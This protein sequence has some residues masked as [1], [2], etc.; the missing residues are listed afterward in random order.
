MKPEDLFRADNIA[1]SMTFKQQSRR[2]HPQKEVVFIPTEEEQLCIQT[3][4]S[5]RLQKICS[6]RNNDVDDTHA[7]AAPKMPL[8]S[9]HQIYD[10][11][12]KE[13]PWTNLEKL[14]KSDVSMKKFTK[15]NAKCSSCSKDYNEK[16]SNRLTINESSP[17][18]PPTTI[19][20]DEND[21]YSALCYNDDFDEDDD[22]IF[23]SDLEDE[24]FALTSLDLMD[25]VSLDVMT[26]ASEDIASVHTKIDEGAFG[27]ELW[28]RLNNKKRVSIKHNSE[29]RLR[30]KYNKYR[31]LQSPESSARILPAVVSY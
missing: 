7:T 23:M 8:R 20:D 5:R 13:D 21:G 25:P 10:A 18:L 12:L 3:S 15:D 6:L 1:P 16:I 11:L 22:S 4:S 26:C 31:T 24:D 27:G 30:T 19:E 17:V 2:R 28:N 14:E 9:S 29:Q